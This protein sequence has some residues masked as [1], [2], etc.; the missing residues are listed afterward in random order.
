MNVLVVDDQRTARVILGEILSAETGLTVLEASSATEARAIAREHAIELAFLDVRL[1]FDMRDRDGLTLLRDLREAN[2]RSVVMVSALRD[3]T[4]IREAFRSGAEDYILKDELEA[5]LILPIVQRV[6]ARQRLEA[7][8]QRLRAQVF[9]ARDVP[10]IVGTSPAIQRLREVVRRVASSDRAVLVTGE[11]GSGKEQTV[12]ALHALGEA[13]DQPLFDVNCGALP[14][15]LV[16][17]YLFGHERGAF[18]G[19]ERRHEGALAAVGRG[20]LFLDEVAELPLALQAKLLRVLETRRYRSVGGTTE[21]N[22]DGRVIAATHADLAARVDA[23]RF[24]EDL[25][26]RLAVLV[27]RVPNLGERRDDI[28]AL[29]THFARQ[30][31]RPLHFDEGAIARLMELPWPGNVRELRNVID[32]IAVFCDDDVVTAGSIDAILPTTRV[33]SRPMREIVDAVLDMESEGDRLAAV[34]RALVDEAIRRAGGNK[35]EA[36]RLLG[37]H[38]KRI[39]RRVQG[40]SSSSG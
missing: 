30:Q 32:R 38:R 24:R 11:S 8:V 37:V 1:S 39:E 34:E 3:S 15:S 9:T 25:Y 23:G 6:R 14:E 29:V 10:G 12:R 7:E 31:P 17:S 18:T 26:H 19:A 36:A 40:R 4:E 27:V 2:V 5:E 28:P 35:S 22:F 33:S 13:P 20:T 16:E 21:R